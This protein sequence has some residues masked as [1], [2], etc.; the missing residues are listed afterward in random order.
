MKTPKKEK[1][2]RLTLDLDPREEQIVKS[3]REKCGASHADLGRKAF[4]LLHLVE[5]GEIIPTTKEG[6]KIPLGLII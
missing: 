6:A 2:V 3:L 5:S 4:R 1:R